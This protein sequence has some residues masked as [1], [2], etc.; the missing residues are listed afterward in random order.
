MTLVNSPRIY[1]ALGYSTT[2]AL[3]ITALYGVLALVFNTICVAFVDRVGRRKLLVPSMVGMGAALCVE[4]TLTR[5][6]PP[7]NT[8]NTD[9]L[10]ASVA[11]NFVFALFFTSLGV[12]SWIYQSEIFPTAVRARG[13]S[14]ST[15]T[16]WAA[17]LIFAQCT[18]IALTRLGYKYFYLFTAFN[19]VAAIL[20]YLYFPE[21]LGRSLEEVYE[22]FDDS[23]AAKSQ[24]TQIY[25][26]EK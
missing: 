12:I 17:N 1:S 16:N 7:S 5:Y 14:L 26:Q 15:F 24:E 20:V 9:A 4:A 25:V 8:P 11:M 10:R 18:P 13:T 6:F 3:F 22:V 23:D 21:T 2:G 19:W